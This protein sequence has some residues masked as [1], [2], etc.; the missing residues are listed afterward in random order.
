MKEILD[1]FMS[2]GMVLFLIWLVI[3]YHRQKGHHKRGNKKD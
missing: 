1:T 2:A 3:G